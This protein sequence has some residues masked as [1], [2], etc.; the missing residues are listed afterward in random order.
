MPPILQKVVARNV[1]VLKAFD[2]PNSPKFRK[3][4]TVYARNGR[5]KTTL[6]AILASAST[7]NGSTVSA[8]HTLGATDRPEITLLFESSGPMLFSN[9]R[10]SDTGPFEVFDSAFIADN[11]YAGE[12]I[13]LE[14]DRSLFTIILGEEGVRLSRHQERINESAKRAASALKEADTALKGDAPADLSLDEFF[15]LAPSATIDADLEQAQKDLR[16]VR[17]ADRLARLRRLQA[18]SVPSAA[19]DHREILRSTVADIETVSRDRL[20]AHFR[21]FSLGRE[22]EA[23]VKFGRDHIHDDRCP[24]CGKSD[25]DE[26]GLVTVYNQIFSETYQAH[27]DAIRAAWQAIEDAIGAEA[28]SKMS[29]TVAGNAEAVREWSEFYNFDSI[30]VADPVPAFAELERAHTALENVYTAKRQS[31]LVVVEAD[32]SVAEAEAAIGSAIEVIENYNAAIAAISRIVAAPAAGAQLTEQQAASRV[33]NLERRKRR[34]DPSVQRRIDA[35]L[36]GKRRDARAKGV[37][38]VVQTRLKAA[39][40]AAAAHYYGRVNHYLLQFGT[41][42]AISQITNSMAGNLGAVDYGLVVRG[43][44]VERGRGR[45]TTDQPSFKNTLSTGDKTTLA[46]AFFLAGLDRLSDLSDRIVVFDDP[47]SSHDT[48]RQ[49]KT[50]EILL[51]LRARCAQTIVLSHDAFFLRLVSRR[52]PEA[53]RI[54][55]EIEYEGAEK[56]SK[57]KVADLDELCQSDHVKTLNAL[58]GYYERREGDPSNIAPGVRRVLETHYRQSHRAYFGRTDNL[59][60]IVSSI[61]D[62]G[63]S[64]PCWSVLA[65]LRACE[66]GTMGGHHGDDA[67]VVSSTPI[68]PD[69]LHGIVRDCLTVMNVI[70]PESPM[71]IAPVAAE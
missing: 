43:H 24:F 30:V 64:H 58:L 46:F 5:G 29:A 10:W 22:G 47:L 54:C 9:G 1:G 15:A 35:Y 50:V 11:L 20:A 32:P 28:R 6:S 69:D 59:G 65:I 41:T 56:W 57:A 48:H 14:H 53:E 23:W 52:T 66:A 62:A 2:T 27:F 7:G 37:R 21:S 44:N 34:H 13:A 33:A 61:E 4:T 17:Q 67:S 45:A 26:L 31:P 3:L 49:N 70:R 42:F 8:R 40:D 51:E 19:T 25:V 55:Y 38:S 36:R 16:A 18:L 60:K 39:N 63:A 12:T 68:D 71:A